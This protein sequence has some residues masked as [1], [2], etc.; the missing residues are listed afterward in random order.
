MWPPP[1]EPAPLALPLSCQP[2]PLLLLLLQL[3]PQWWVQK[4]VQ[5]QIQK[6]FHKQVQDS[7]ERLPLL[8]LR[9]LLQLRPFGSLLLPLPPQLPLT[10]TMREMKATKMAKKTKTTSATLAKKPG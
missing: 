3:R 10:M 5:K 4:H 6:Q 8:L 1:R 2:P 9:L 7:Q